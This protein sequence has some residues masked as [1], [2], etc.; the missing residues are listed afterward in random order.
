MKVHLYG[1]NA[2]GTAVLPGSLP[3]ARRIPI[4]DYSYRRFECCI[5]PTDAAGSALTQGR[6][7]GRGQETELGA[8]CRAV[9]SLQTPPFP[10][11]FLFT[12]PALEG[13][14]WR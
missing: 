11:P 7:A 2:S 4:W 10:T 1:E 14:A 9:W 13:A 12:P 6:P 8:P 5:R 3:G